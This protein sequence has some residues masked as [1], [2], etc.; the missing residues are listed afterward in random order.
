ML[1]I[2]RPEIDIRDDAGHERSLA[3]FGDRKI[4]YLLQNFIYDVIAVVEFVIVALSAIAGKYLY[5]DLI[6]GSSAVEA[7]YPIIGL[8]GAVLWQFTYSSN[9][10]HSRDDF[11]SLKEDAARISKSLLFAFMLLAFFGYALKISGIYSRGWFFCWFTLALASLLVEREIAKHVIR[12]LMKDGRLNSRVAVY[13]TGENSRKLCENLRSQIMGASVVGIYDDKTF[14]P[15]DKPRTSPVTGGLSDLI[16]DGMNN[17]FDWVIIA[18]PASR[19]GQILHIVNQLS[20]LP[21]R[22]QNCPDQVTLGPIRSQ[23]SYLGDKYVLNIYNKP[24]SEWAGVSK[25]I[26]DYALG[27]LLF[28]LLIPSM[29]II[30][31]AIKLDTKGPVFFR[32]KRHG[33]NHKMIDVMKFR[34]MTVLED[35]TSIK[36]ATRSDDRVTRV[37]RFLRR[38]SLDEL[39]QLINVLRGEMSLVGPRPHALAHN[40]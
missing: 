12:S 22:V 13:G 32:Q 14:S 40:E 20:V 23:I 18:L 35:G 5:I 8:I 38:T 16:R 37:G 7:N 33:Y 31:M 11:N 6:G 1:Q 25:Q 24:Q 17:K 15:E 27:T 36:Q 2:D 9:R 21:I 39:P 19:N 30:A 4:G 29:A 10:N 28:L 34:T 26:M 3:S